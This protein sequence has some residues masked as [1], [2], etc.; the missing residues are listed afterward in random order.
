ME[1]TQSSTAVALNKRKGLADDILK[2][3]SVLP[4]EKINFTQI[5]LALQA[6]SAEPLAFEQLRLILE[7]KFGLVPLD[8]RIEEGLALYKAQE[9]T[10]K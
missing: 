2:A 7:Q 8:K 9:E 1:S 3:V 5:Q 4:K 6:L 10:T